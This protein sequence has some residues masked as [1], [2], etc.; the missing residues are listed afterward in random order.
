[1]SSV[2]LVVVSVNV[3]LALLFSIG[4][5]PIM[6]WLERRVAG[7]IQDRL[8]PN[9]CNIKGIRLGGLIQS[10]A[11]MLKLVFKEDFR[12]S[13]IRERFLFSLSPVIVFVCA[14]LAFMVVPFADNLV[15]FDEVYVMQAVPVELGVLWFLAFAGLGVYGIMIGGWASN[16][17]YSL[18]GSI[19][20]SAQMISYE[21]AMALSLVSVL[22]TYGSL[23]LVDAVNFQAQ[24]IFGFIPAWGVLIQPVATIIFII[25]AFAEANRTPFDIAEGESEIVGG[26]HTEYSAMRFGLFFVGEYVAMSTSSAFIV[27]LFFGGYHLPWL[28]TQVLKGNMPTV[29]A[30]AMVVIPL[31]SFIFMRWVYKNNIWL[32]KNDA[33]NKESIWLLKILLFKNV[34]ILSLLGYALFVGIGENVTNILTCILQVVTFAIKLLLV[35]FFF[36]WVRWTLPRFRYDQ[37]QTLGWKVLM[38][39]AIANIF[40]T[41]TFIVVM[42]V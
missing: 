7:F 24:L 36:I 16:N 28:D 20:S 30:V 6:V 39:L 25:T 38:P 37:L 32:D 33:R 27:T 12:S 11:D 34:V 2:L 41:A 13:T 19:R 42:G 9:R 35:N 15:L 8:G 4:A 10:F 23:N 40:I 21:A 29:L 14:F 17:K 26:F 5:A 3:I 22:V 1:M 18:L 31:I